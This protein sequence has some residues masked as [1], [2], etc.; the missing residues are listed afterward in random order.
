M[1]KNNYKIGKKISEKELCP[2]HLLKNQMLAYKRDIKKL[3]KNKEFFVK[4][5]C[6]ACGSS[7]KD[8][9]FK[10]YGFS[11]QICRICETI[12]M[13]P[14][15]SEK[16]MAEYYANSENY[17][18]WSK[19][20]F[21][22]SEETRKNNIHKLWLSRIKRIIKTEKTKHN[23]LLEV[24][25]GFGTFGSLVKSD[26][27]FKKYVGLEPSPELYKVCKK[28]KLD[29]LNK[30]LEDFSANLKFDVVVSFEVIE[31]T[32]NPKFFLK[33]IHQNLKKSG[34]V[35]LSCP[36]GKGFD[37]NV[38]K[39]K[40]QAVDSEHVN[41]FNTESIKL[42]LSN[43]G[44]KVVSVFTPGRLDAEIVREEAIKKKF[45]LDKFLKN[46]LIDNWNLI[47]WEFQNFLA[48]NN[49]SSH[50]WVVAQKK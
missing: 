46:I 21:P 15:P 16:Q 33:K 4:I 5:N 25:S 12:F 14:R 13:S 31:H 43:T 48:V 39:Q 26:D 10:K 41:L 9:K 30:K 2:P 28:K 37:I 49:L 27:F 38:L 7:K 47:G 6:P 17:E 35:F 40:S 22:L 36:N 19:F 32:F 24:G 45:K 50:M 42:L 29:V 23:S 44:Y 8:F 34:L 20:I 3:Q 18:Y 11:F 1:N